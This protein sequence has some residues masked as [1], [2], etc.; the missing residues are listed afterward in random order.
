M[1]YHPAQSTETPAE[2]QSD[3]PDRFNP[4]QTTK[5]IETP[6]RDGV[7]LRAHLHLPEGCERPPVILVRVPYG[8]STP[9]MGYAQLGRFWARKGYACVVQDVRGKFS[10]DGAF[11]PMVNE[12]ND[13]FDTVEW[14]SRQPWCNG[15][16]GMWGES[17]YGFTS[18]AAAVEQPPALA[19]IAP[20]DIATDRR[21]IWFRQGAFALNTN[22]AWALAM[23]AKGYADLSRVDWWHLPLVDMPTAAGL[24]GQFFREMIDNIDNPAWFAQRGL[25]DQLS[26]ITVPVLFWTGWYDNYTNELLRDYALLDR[27]SPN[28]EKIH[29]FVGPWDHESTGGGTDRAICMPL[30]PTDAHRW[31][32]YQRFFDRYLMGI[33]NGFGA[34]G[35]VEYFTVGSNQWRTS[36]EW[37]PRAAK[38]TPL[39]LRSKGRLSFDR[40]QEKEAPD[41]YIYDP[42]DPVADTVGLDCWATC[43]VLGDRREI[44]KRSDVL[45]YTSVPLEKD[46]EITGPIQAVL[47]ASSDATDTDFTVTL[48]DVFEDGT[49]NQIQE[50]IVRARYRDDTF[51]P[52]LIEPGRVYK[53]V[54]DLVASSYLV[55]AGH[56]IRVD[57][58]SSCFNRYDRNPNTGEK[59]GYASE[60]KIAR[61]EIHHSSEFSSHVLLPVM[62]R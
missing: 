40:P 45:V 62:V 50:G 28:P 61:Q 56:C 43:K 51:R 33:Q 25:R 9:A 20:G 59:I 57:V 1:S 24:E 11:E 60:V 47:Y 10:S 23:D 37:P 46:V 52:S 8:R 49:A 42:A 31:A 12:R 2:I 27:S 15:R 58:S 34:D 36:G 16:V 54:I 44:E 17:Y 26:R 3:T 19:C 13:G 53:Y 22:G 39:Y 38:S 4:S 29:L 48:V 18:L 21:N 41:R 14:V 5:E 7:I 6:M 55:K 30:P 35:K 32:V